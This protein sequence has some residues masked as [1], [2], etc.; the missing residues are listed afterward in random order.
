MQVFMVENV[1]VPV[2][3]IVTNPLP[4][5]PAPN[6]NLQLQL[7]SLPWEVKIAKATT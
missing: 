5:T 3:P 2:A 4:F 7:I 6:T 1:I